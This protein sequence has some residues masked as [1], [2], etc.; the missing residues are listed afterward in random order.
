MAFCAVDVP[1]YEIRVRLFLRACAPTPALPTSP[2]NTPSGTSGP[3]CTDPV[4]RRLRFS[5]IRD[6]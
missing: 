4:G 1:E 5:V 2:I 6:P 3:P